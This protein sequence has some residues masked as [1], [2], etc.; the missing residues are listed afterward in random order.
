MAVVC[1]LWKHVEMSFFNL[2]VRH[3]LLFSY[4]YFLLSAR[5][6]TV[7]VCSSCSQKVNK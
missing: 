5:I 7:E 3:G 4:V 1:G 2:E 6:A